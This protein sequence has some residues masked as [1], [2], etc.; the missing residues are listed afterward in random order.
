MWGGDNDAFKVEYTGGV[1]KTGFSI[2]LQTNKIWIK[3]FREVFVTSISF[4]DRI[5]YILEENSINIHQF[6]YNK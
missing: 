4:V 1:T 6:I 5:F 2:V 3:T